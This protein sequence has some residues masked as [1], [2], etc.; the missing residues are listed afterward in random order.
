MKILCYDTETAG[1]PLFREPSEHPD[2][3]HIVQLGAA[4][5]DAETR[6]VEERVNLISRPDGWTIPDEVA[7]I[8]GITTERAMDEGVPEADLVDELVSLW[9]RCGMR[10]GY[11]E[12]FD[13]RIVRIA[14]MRFLPDAVFETD[15]SAEP[16]AD[17]WKAGKARCAAVMATPICKMPPTERM[18]AAG[19]HHHK[20]PKLSEAYELLLGSPM[21][22]AHD[23]MAD[24]DACL[25]VYWHLLDLQTEAEV[26]KTRTA[27][28][29]AA[30][31]TGDLPPF[32]I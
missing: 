24:V 31:A 13:A 20:T 2:Q 17:A 21:E 16:L 6:E 7:A 18:L 30:V 10:L 22:N 4:L 15:T 8:H 19:R 23:A 5:V 25:A 29:P 12:P 11:N 32:M 1:L 3:P 26:P 9:K 27:K 28:Q 14:L